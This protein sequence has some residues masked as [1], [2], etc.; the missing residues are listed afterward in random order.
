ME[1]TFKVDAEKTID[2]LKHL[3]VALRKVTQSALNETAQV[4]KRNAYKALR[5]STGFKIRIKKAK[6]DTLQ[7]MVAMNYYTVDSKFG[8]EMMA[9]KT[10]KAKGS[11]HTAMRSGKIKAFEQFMPSG[12]HG[13]FRR[14]TE[15]RLPINLLFSLYE[16][17]DVINRFIAA[18]KRAVD[19]VFPSAFR[20]SYD[21]EV[22]RAIKKAA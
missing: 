10:K 16:K 8:G 14:T 6:E 3:P 18:V 4:A 11:P 19:K 13:I 15:K 9:I 12:K 22:E 7:A 17:T 21:K 1:F 2:S 20:K 5:P